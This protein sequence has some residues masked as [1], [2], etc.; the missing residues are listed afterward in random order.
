MTKDILVDREF[1][2]YGVEQFYTLDMHNEKNQNS[3]KNIW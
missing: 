3:D 2:N 1:N